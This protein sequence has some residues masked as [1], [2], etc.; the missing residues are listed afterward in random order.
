MVLVLPDGTT[1]APTYTTGSYTFAAPIITQ[2]IGGD[3]VLAAGGSFITIQGVHFGVI[4]TAAIV[5]RFGETGVEWLMHSCT[6]ITDDTQIQCTV[7]P[8]GGEHH[9]HVAALLRCVGE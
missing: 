6:V 5:G 8:N 2:L 1:S 7:P 4:G 3:G 9:I